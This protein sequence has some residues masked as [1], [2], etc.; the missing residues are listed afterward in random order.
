MRAKTIYKKAYIFDL[1]DTLI[2][3]PAKIHVY[4][5]G[6]F[7]KSLTPKEYNFYKHQPSDKLD[8][9]DFLDGEMILKAKK[10]TVWPVI[11]NVSNAIKEERSTSEIYIL[12]AR[13]QTVKSYI[14]E[15]LKRNG[16]EIEFKNIITMGDGKGHFDIAD[17]KRKILEQLRKKYDEI[18]IFDDNP[19]TIQLAASIPGIK[20]K[21]V[22]SRYES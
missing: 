12:T 17:E 16:I 15:F 6:T 10:Y 4:R 14:Y 13:D 18:I 2:K 22:E 5:N 3:T 8:F 21:L 7:I 9:K 1:D 19:K 20:T 11:R